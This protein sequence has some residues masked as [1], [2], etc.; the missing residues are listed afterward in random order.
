[1]TTTTI[2]G[3]AATLLRHIHAPKGAANTY[4]NRDTTGPFICVMIDPLYWNTICGI[5]STYEGYRVVVE[6][7]EPT[8][9]FR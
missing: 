3:A 4:V 9:A 7:Q 2:Q 5:P 1:M 6:K 8:V